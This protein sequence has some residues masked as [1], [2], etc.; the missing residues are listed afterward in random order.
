M[1]SSELNSINQINDQVIDFANTLIDNY[2]IDDIELDSNLKSILDVGNII[3]GNGQWIVDE[4]TTKESLTSEAKA[5][6]DERIDSL[7][8]KLRS[9]LPLN[10]TEEESAGNPLSKEN[11][12][13]NPFADGEN[14]FGDE[15]FTPPPG[16]EKSPLPSQEIVDDI[17]SVEEENPVVVVKEKNN[18]TT[19][20][21]TE[22][23]VVVVEEINNPIQESETENPVAV[24]E[25]INNPTQES[26]TENPVVDSG[27]N[28][29]AGGEGENPNEGGGD[30]D[31]YAG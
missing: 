27:E 31:E 5:D 24:V 25:E 12:E 13:E 22:N 10:E 2:S 1:E 18:S 26:Q 28:P 4:C 11:S 9:R 3:I 15:E 14:P 21:E 7:F 20:N 16:Y 19:E 17:K 6:V 23:P 30:G 8:N 29:F